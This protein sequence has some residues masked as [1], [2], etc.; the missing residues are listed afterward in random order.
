MA[1]KSV[2]NGIIFIEGNEECIKKLGP[3][4]YK[5]EKFYNT[6]LSNIDNVKNQLAE[7]A[8]QMGGNAIIDF[9][10]GQKNVSWFKSMLLALDDNVVWFGTGTVVL[11]D[12]AKYNDII[13]ENK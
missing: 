4:Q 11:L 13:N 7:K 1:Y 9:K 2:F 3:V 6:Q 8:K 12:E 5:R 10:Y